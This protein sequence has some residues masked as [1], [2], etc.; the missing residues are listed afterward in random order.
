MHSLV[1]I[2]VSGNCGSGNRI[3]QG[4]DVQTLLSEGVD[5]DKGYYVIKAPISPIEEFSCLVRNMSVILTTP[6]YKLH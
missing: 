5:L 6:Q 2:R 4:L 3:M 1:K